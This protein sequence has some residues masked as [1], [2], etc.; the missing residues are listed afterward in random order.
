MAAICAGVERAE[1]LLQLERAR[2]AVG[3]GH[4]LVEREA[5]Q[6]RERLLRQQLVGL[7]SSPVKWIERSVAAMTRDR[8]SPARPTCRRPDRLLA[9][10]PLVP[11]SGWM[12]SPRSRR[13]RARW[14]ER[15]FAGPTPAQEQAW[16]AIA[17]GAHVLVQA[18]TGSGKTLAAFLVGD[19]PAE[20]D[21][22]RRAAAALRLAR[23]R[24]STTTSSGTCAGRSPGS[25][26][27]SRVGGAHRRHAAARAPADA[28]QAARHPDHDTRVA[29]PAADLAGPRDA[30]RRRDADPRRGA[31]RRRHEARRAPGAL[32][33][34]ARA[35][36][37]AARSSGS[38]SRRR[39]GRSRRSAGSSPDGRPITLVDAGTRK[40][41]DLEVVV[42]V[43]D[44][45]E[46]GSTASLSHPVLADG[47]EMAPGVRAGE[48]LDLAVDLS[49]RCSSSSRRTA[50]R[51]S[52]STT[53][54]SP[55]GSRCG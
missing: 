8:A 32:A 25:A 44:M 6:E 55:S 24:R 36:R 33:R 27:S 4:L 17:T 2:E 20:R 15:A 50:R 10:A 9:G 35:A 43:E 45:R 12:R 30:A 41:L 54:A 26:P 29:L 46:L 11:W 47:V 22:R 18:P 48:Q 53:A 1:P 40:E 37:R 52:S 51:S 42:P 34:A 31:R 13:R 28:A 16:P 21:A 7:G 14:F 38:G 19:R 5:D 3:T 49:R 23:S 39:S